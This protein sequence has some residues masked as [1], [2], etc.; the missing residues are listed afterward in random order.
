MDG[1]L[2]D[3]RAARLARQKALSIAAT[4]PS[5]IVIGG[6]QVAQCQ[7]KILSKPTTAEKARQQLGFMSGKA[8]TFHSAACV[9]PPKR[10]PIEF[11]DET[12]VVFRKL[13]TEEI[14]RYVEMDEPLQSS[15]SFKYEGLGMHLFS[16]I[17]TEDPSAI[18]GL[19]MMKLAQIL[20]SLGVNP[21]LDN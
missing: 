7:G 20:R 2:P 8:V 11:V 16:S 19:P 6:D 1:E 18:L 3:V 4:M 12:L 9:T 10:A 13:S 17:K 21:L 5:A 14:V 15:G